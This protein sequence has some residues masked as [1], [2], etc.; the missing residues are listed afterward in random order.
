[1][2]FKFNVQ[3]TEQDYLD[4]NAFWMTK[5]HYGK[6]QL[7]SMRV[8]TAIL[9]LIFAL[10]PLINGNFLGI[11]PFLILLVIFELG[12]P[13]FLVFSI[14]GQLKMMK[15]SGKMGYSPS[16]V[17]EF[18]DDRFIETT[19]ENKTEHFYSAIEKINVISGKIIYIHVNN[20]MAYLLPFACFE[21][22]RQYDDFMAFI[23][24]RNSNIDF[25]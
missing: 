24:T 11:I 25:Y 12:L 4:Y 15:K 18:L 17:L 14:K 5:S 9:I 21:S 20:V 7:N 16:A 22:E 3:L 13:R 6:K 8:M 19:P 2:L 1:M 23:K 10:I